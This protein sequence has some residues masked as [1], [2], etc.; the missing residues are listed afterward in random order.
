MSSPI[1]LT[2]LRP[3]HQCPMTS[4]TPLN[5]SRPPHKLPVSSSNPLKHL[6]PLHQTPMR[7][8]K[9]FKS[10]RPHPQHPMNWPTSLHHQCL[11]HRPHPLLAHTTTSLP[12]SMGSSPILK[13][14]LLNPSK[15]LTFMFAPYVP[16]NLTISLKPF[17][18][19]IGALLCKLNLMPYTTITHGILLGGPLLRIW[20]GVNGFFVSNAIRI[21]PLIVTRH[22]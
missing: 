19:L 21:A 16:S 12:M 2:R 17:V 22:D 1:S 5:N 9:T 7:S 4:S 10:P 8:P 11:H 15:R 20:L 13:T 18:T 3:H 14:T 6:R